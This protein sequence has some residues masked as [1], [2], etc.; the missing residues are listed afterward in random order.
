[1]GEGEA[2]G[3]SLCRSASIAVLLRVCLTD[4]MIGGSSATDVLFL[5]RAQGPLNLGLG[6]D[7]P[8]PSSVGNKNVANCC[9]TYCEVC[10]NNRRYWKEIEERF[11]SFFFP[12]Y[13][14]VWEC[15]GGRY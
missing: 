9:K 15:D 5:E 1:M 8:M 11:I 13:E 14:I 10:V 7:I 6:C 4:S 12:G 2:A 3:T